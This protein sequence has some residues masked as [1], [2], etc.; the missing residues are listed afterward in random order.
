NLRVLLANLR[1]ELGPYV[2]IT[3]KTAAINPESNIQTDLSVLEEKLSVSRS[4]I[5]RNGQL[6]KEMAADLSQSLQAFQNMLL[7]GFYLKDGLGFEE[8]LATEREWLWTR[9]VEALDDLATDYLQW[10]DYRAGIEQAQRLVT[11][12]PMREEGHQLLM[13]L[14]AADGQMSSAL[15][16]YE[17]CVEILDQ[18]LGV[19]PHS[20][21]TALFEQM[22]AGSWEIP[23]TAQLQ[24]ADLRIPIP[25]NLPRPVAPVLGRESESARLTRFLADPTSSLISVVGPGGIGKT[26]LALDAARQ[27]LKDEESPFR[28]GILLV[29]LGAIHEL[30][31]IPLSIA[32]AVGFQFKKEGGDETAQIFGYL[33]DQALLLVLDNVEQ[34]L[35]QNNENDFFGTLLGAAP[36]VKL[37]ATSRHRL[38]LPNE[39]VLS[40]DGLTFPA[41][42]PRLA[43]ALHRYSGVKLFL[44]SVRRAQGHVELSGDA[45]HAVG[46]ICRLV[47]GMPLA[48]V[49]AA[50]GVELL[51]PVEIA[52]ELSNDMALLQSTGVS[53]LPSRQQ[54]MQAVFNHSW[55][56]LTA[57]EQQVLARM[58]IFRGSCTRQVAQAVSGGSLRELLSLAHKSLLMRDISTGSFTMHPLLRQLAAE[59]LAELGQAPAPLHQ[60]AFETLETLY[61]QN[62]APFYGALADHAEMAGLIDQAR[63]YLRLAADQ[64]RDL[65]QSNLAL[66]FYGRAVGLTRSAEPEMLYK[67]RIEMVALLHLLGR[68]DLQLEEIT[69]LAGIAEHL[70]DDRKR[71]EVL[72]KKA[73]YAEAM[74]NYAESGGHAE[75]AVALADEELDSD[76]LAEAYLAWGNAHSRSGIFDQA[77]EKLEA[78]IVHAEKAELLLLAGQS[79]QILGIDS[80]YQG[81]R[82]G[83]KRYF[84]HNIEIFRRLENRAGEAAGL[85]NLGVLMLMQCNYGAASDYIEQTVKIFHELNDVRNETIGLI[86]LGSVAHKLGQFKKA[87]INY[88][89]GLHLANQTA[90]YQSQREAHNWLGN[91]FVDQGNFSDAAEHYAAALPLAEKLTYRGHVVEAQVALASLKLANGKPQEAYAQLEDVLSEITEE[92]LSQ[93]DDILRLFL[94]TYR[95]LNAVQHEQARPILETAHTH[96]QKLAEQIENGEHRRYFMENVSIHRQIMAKYAA[97]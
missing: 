43:V 51:S 52:A 91:L 66:S 46:E 9:V 42:K 40:L 55:N 47:Q 22:Q 45:L 3:R 62:L 61:S 21:T 26:V 4:E 86:N 54:S 38:N 11:L 13:Q 81:D 5:D 93:A 32:S 25:H 60:L 41:E 64:A 72:V 53:E 49:L 35:Q 85:G 87:K 56:L 24:P 89:Q 44:Q 37:L 6:S 68:R 12:D 74:G 2:S 57:A 20:Y 84:E 48:I 8:W 1:K 97:L 36:Q 14:W 77:K 15:A 92:A 18:E 33:K 28:D 83:A 29:E 69:H 94:S 19:Q 59:K 80:F 10:G 75:K 67:L 76:L 39:T 17:R 30:S 27:M 71:S 58:S 79:Y 96:L 73:R 16:Q 88:K 90:D 23:K 82:I 70:N 95:I 50:A 65:F 63:I 34:L 78:A 7:P 31:Q